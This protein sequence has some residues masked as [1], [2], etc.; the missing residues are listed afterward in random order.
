MLD[1]RTKE[2]IAIGCSVAANCHPCVKFHLDKARSLGI[3]GEAI[4]DAI[5]VGRRVRQGAAAEMDEL[6]TKLTIRQE[7]G[8]KP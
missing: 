7:G 2:L 3:E 8:R 1:D 4:D 5:T 6:L